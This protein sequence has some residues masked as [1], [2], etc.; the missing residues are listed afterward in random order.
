MKLKKA[1][2]YDNNGNSGGKPHSTNKNYGQHSQKTIF[3]AANWVVHLTSDCYNK[4][5]S[6]KH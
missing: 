2:F 1:A 5:N 6:L 3:K 4:C